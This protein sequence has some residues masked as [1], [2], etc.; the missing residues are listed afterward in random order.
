ME[1]EGEQVLD[2]LLKKAN[3]GQLP[4][5]KAAMIKRLH[6]RVA[7]GHGLNEMQE[8]LVRDLGMEYGIS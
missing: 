5:K 1:M 2:E 3:A 4:E 6:E 7:A 8:E